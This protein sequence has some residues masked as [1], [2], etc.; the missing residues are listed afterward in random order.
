MDLKEIVRKAT[1]E[2]KFKRSVWEKDIFAYIEYSGKRLKIKSEHTDKFFNFEADDIL[3][4]DWVFME[5]K[6]SLSQ[7]IV[8]G[9]PLDPYDSHLEICDVKEFIKNIKNI[10]NIRVINGQNAGQIQKD[11]IENIDK[12][13]GKELI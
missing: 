8:T 1:S 13:A 4:D 7:N 12:L 2:S 10:I 6:I 3:A 11:I 9:E 5:E